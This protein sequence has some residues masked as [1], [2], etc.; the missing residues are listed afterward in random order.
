[1]ITENTLYAD[2]CMNMLQACG[3]DHELA[4]EGLRSFA[5]KYFH[6][7]QTVIL[8]FI[9]DSAIVCSPEQRYFVAKDSDDVNLLL[10]LIANV[11]PDSVPEKFEKEGPLVA[12]LPV[13][14]EGEDDG[15]PTAQ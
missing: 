2:R 1:M 12:T 4:K 11:Y 13:G 3:A 5:P 15:T 14:E 6:W 8:Q 7:G 9:D 10:M